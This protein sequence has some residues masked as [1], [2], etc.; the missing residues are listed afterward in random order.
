MCLGCTVLSILSNTIL[1]PAVADWGWDGN[2][3]TGE[4][5][6][7][8]EEGTGKATDVGKEGTG[9]ASHKKEQ[10]NHFL[11][12]L[13]Y[14]KIQK[15]TAHCPMRSQHHSHLLWELTSWVV[16]IHFEVLVAPSL[17]VNMWNR[18]GKWWE[19]TSGRWR[20]LVVIIWHCLH[21]VG[22]M[23]TNNHQFFGVIIRFL[24]TMVNDSSFHWWAASKY[25][26]SKLFYHSFLWCSMFVNFESENT[27]VVLEEF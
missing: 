15:N 5:T 26:N 1:Y 11:P 18:R 27:M 13:H 23:I 22:I 25:T 12:S 17:E 6:G 19:R 8:G 7:A 20:W 10:R 21:N 2:V 14:L 9:E 16:Y 4:A 24:I 3:T